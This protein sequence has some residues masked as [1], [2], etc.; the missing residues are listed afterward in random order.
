MT[1]L[2]FGTRSLR[3]IA[4]MT[5]LVGIV[6]FPAVGQVRMDMNKSGPADCSPGPNQSS[7]P[8]EDAFLAENAAAMK[9]MMKD[10]S[11]KPT[12]DIDHDFVAMMAPHHQGAISMAITELRHEHNERLK[13]IAQEIVV[14]QQQEISAM[15]LAVGDPLPPPSASPTGVGKSMTHEDDCMLHMS[16]PH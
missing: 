2:R 9:M 5:C 11:P 8:N 12:G 15:K 6:V 13:R 4:G 14:T 1:A 10:M 7:F 3:P 16:S